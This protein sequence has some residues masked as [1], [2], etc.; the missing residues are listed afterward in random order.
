MVE[1]WKDI[2]IEKNGVLHNYSGIYQVSN[3][4]RVRSLKFGKIKVMKLK[5]DG[6]GY[7]EVGLRKNGEKQERFRVNRLVATA[8][9]IN[10]D[11]VNKTEVNHINEDKTLNSIENLEWVTRKQNSNHGTRNRRIIE[12]KNGKRTNKIICLETGIV[13]S[14]MNEIKRKFNLNVSAC[15]RNKSKTCGGFHWQ[16]YNDY[17]IEKLI[18]N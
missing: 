7:L 10:D 16:Y 14:S 8:F 17:L 6:H 11:P 4:G 1:E 13:Y 12:K 2:I 3:M 9:I 5:K 18:I 15:C